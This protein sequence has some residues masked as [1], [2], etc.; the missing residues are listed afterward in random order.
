MIRRTHAARATARPARSA[1]RRDPATWVSFGA[2]FAFGVLNST[3]GPVMPYLRQSEHLS[4]VVVALHQ[5]AFATGGMAAGVLAASGGGRRRRTITVGLAGG[6]LAGVLL[7]YGRVLPVTLVAALLMSGLATAA[8]IRVW[9]LL[10]DLHGSQRAV[11]MT[12]GEVAVSLAGILTPALVSVCAASWVSW[13]FSFMV[14]L[15]LVTTAAVVVSMTPLPDARADGVDPDVHPAVDPAEDSVEH[16]RAPGRQSALGG[17]DHRPMVRGLVTIFA[18]VALE[19]TLSFWAASYLHDDV[20]IARNVSVAMVSGLY[21]ANL[22]GR[23]VASRIA[24][25]WS[26]EQVLLLSMVISLI[27]V[28]VLLGAHGAVVAGIGLLLTGAG[29]GGMFP[30]AS[31]MHVAASRETADQAMGQI[32]A[33]AGIGQIV[34]PLVTGALAQGIGLRGSLLV[35]P[36][37]ILVAATTVR[38][39]R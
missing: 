32:L 17:D 13:R 11:A 29:I 28:P 19:F 23:L 36:V 20:G 35:L 14:A 39:A 8:L 4:Y 22:L 12:E 15:V 26:A 38:P 6:A 3:L 25:R 31:S 34:G 5:V 30:L 27:G 7:G 2:L 1:Y 10:A 37:L 24:R 18:V 16:A 21:A 33:V 9:G